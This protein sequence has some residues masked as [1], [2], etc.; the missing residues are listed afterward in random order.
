[1]VSVMKSMKVEIPSRYCMVSLNILKSQ[2]ILFIR[3]FNAKIPKDEQSIIDGDQKVTS[4]GSTLWNMIDKLKF[5]ILNRESICKEKWTH[6][7][8]KKCEKNQG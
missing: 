8:T 4:N 2:E 3:D 1:M 5:T 6:I 7:N